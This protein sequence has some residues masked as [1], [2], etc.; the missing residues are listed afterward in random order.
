MKNKILFALMA[1]TIYSAQAQNNYRFR[2]PVLFSGA[3][4]STGAIYKF[5]S[6]K[7]GIDAYVTIIKSKNA[8]IDQIDDSTK[9]AYAWQPFIKINKILGVNDTAYIDFLIQF[10]KSNKLDTQKEIIMT[11][12]DCD[13]SGINSYKEIIQTPS[14]AKFTGYSSTN[15]SHYTN[16][17]I[18]A[19]ISGTFTYNNIDTLNYPAMAEIKYS[20]T[21]SFKLRIG[22]LGRLTSVNPN[23][24]RQFSFYFKDFGALYTALPINQNPKKENSKLGTL[25]NS[26]NFYPN[27]FMNFIEVREESIC[28]VIIKNIDGKLVF[29]KYYDSEESATINTEE[30]L[31][32][33][34]ILEVRLEN[35]EKLTKLITKE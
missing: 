7:P 22:I 26:I 32:G 21:S 15:I 29:S 13:G 14:P 25:E 27:P 19:L 3:Q 5:N 17:G 16:A 30:F 34:Y 6:V 11:V 35:G 9:Y 10:K 2:K 8:V 24:I 12:V 23:P 28:S 18:E 20:N 4:N 1:L 31:P 33:I